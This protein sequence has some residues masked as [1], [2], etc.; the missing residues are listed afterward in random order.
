LSTGPRSGVSGRPAEPVDLFDG[1][2]SDA[3]GER[4][5]ISVTE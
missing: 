2:A 3:L 1:I 4:R 5:F